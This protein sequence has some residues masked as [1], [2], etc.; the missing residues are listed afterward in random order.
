MK[1]D[2][3]NKK[4]KIRRKKRNRQQETE[5]YQYDSTNE[6]YEI[7]LKIDNDE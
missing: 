6:T 2:G 7:L 4:R 3:R 1:I 5:E